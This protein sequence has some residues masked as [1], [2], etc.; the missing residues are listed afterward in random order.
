[1]NTY[2]RVLLSVF[3][4]AASML[5]LTMHAAESQ[6]PLMDADTITGVTEETFDHLQTATCTYGGNCDSLIQSLSRRIIM[7]IEDKGQMYWVNTTDGLPRLNRYLPNGFYSDG[8]KY[9]LVSEGVR[10]RLKRGE[11]YQKL[12]TVARYQGKVSFVTPVSENDFSAMLSSCESYGPGNAA[13]EE[14]YKQCYAIQQ[15]GKMI[16]ERLEGKVIMRVGYGGQLLYVL[17]DTSDVSIQPLSVDMA[18]SSFFKYMQINAK[19]G[20]EG[21]VQDM[22]PFARF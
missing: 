8:N 20:H 16:A 9:Y 21:A 4:S 3:I 15:K 18:P 10:I 19:A 5:P 11:A 14:L 7:R 1:M 22:I 2:T 12:L 13:T 17:P 6:F